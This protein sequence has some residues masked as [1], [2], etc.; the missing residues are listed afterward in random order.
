MRDIND[1]DPDE[2]ALDTVSDIEDDDIEDDSDIELVDPDPPSKTS[3][4]SKSSS[5]ASKSAPTTS[6]GTKSTT[7]SRRT[8]AV[9]FMSAI[10]S[11]LDPAV[12]EARDE[13]RYARKLAAAEIET[14]RQDNRDLRLRND[15]LNDKIHYLTMQLQQ[16]QLECAQLRARLEMYDM[17]RSL[18]GQ[19]SHHEEY[20]FRSPLSPH[21]PRRYHSSYSTVSPCTPRF[22]YDMSLDTSLHSPPRQAPD[23]SQ[24]VA[25]A[26]TG[27]DTLASIAS[28]SA[29]QL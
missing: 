19:H 8:Q 22:D 25:S 11:S 9:N 12:R 15:A 1:P 10:A 17:F 3:T 4:S 29:S 23:Q 26:P 7:A 21:T 24:H 18:R 5:K 20:L 27:L 13:A 2:D 14:L 6:Q 16:Q 28:A